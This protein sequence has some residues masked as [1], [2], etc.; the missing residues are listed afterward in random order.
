MPRRRWT[1]AEIEAM[2]QAGVID[3][4]E[5][6]E[7]IDG[8]VVPRSPKG[9]RHETYKGSLLDY[10]LRRRS[11]AYRI[12]PETTFRLDESSFLEPDIVFY[13]AKVKVPQLAPS[14][15][16]LA[17]EISDS[18]LA[19]DSGRKAKLYARYGVPSLW[20]IDVNTFVTHVFE[21]PSTDG[22]VTHRTIT[23]DEVLAPGFAPELAVKL[24]EL[25]LI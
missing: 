8:D 16:L 20:V 15:T 10:W 9:S 1:V 23:A 24:S 5:R 14:N 11:D 6:F 19:Y 7:L 2:V 25:P 22:F 3:E 17:V 21:K 4:D 12:I 13:D 18:T